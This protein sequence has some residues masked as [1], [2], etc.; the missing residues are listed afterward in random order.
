MIDFVFPQNK[1]EIPFQIWNAP[2][3]DLSSAF[4]YKNAQ[5]QFSYP[6]KKD[7]HHENGSTDRL[8]Q[9]PS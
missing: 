7:S 2:V 5:I 1:L 6:K 8:K 9:D 4:L 3:R